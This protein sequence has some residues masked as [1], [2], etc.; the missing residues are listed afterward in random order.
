MT[1]GQGVSMKV[2]SSNWRNFKISCRYAKD[3]DV[4]TVVVT[5]K[6]EPTLFP[7]QIS[8]TLLAL[9]PY[10]FPFVDL[11]TNGIVFL[12]KKKEY[13]EHLKHWYQLGMTTIAI[14]IVHYDNEKN[15]A[16]YAPKGKYFNLK[17]LIDYLHELGFSVRLTCMMIKGGIDGVKE[18]QNLIAFAKASKVEQITIRP[19][20]KPVNGADKQV[21]KW[22]VENRITDQRLRQI[23]K[24]LQKNG[25]LLRNL[26][27]GAQ[28]FDLEGQNIC[29]SNCLTIKPS[30]DEVRQLIFFPDGHLRYDWQ[31]PGAILL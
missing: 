7:E 14:S 15:E 31:Y 17:K 16:I 21:V 2:P 18:V 10:G 9:E 3:S 25:T 28:V 19:I 6:G 13:K 12:Q 27:H 11:Q 1:P 22:V 30:E 23:H 5:G 29:L 4:S 24:H 26:V 8:N 20:D